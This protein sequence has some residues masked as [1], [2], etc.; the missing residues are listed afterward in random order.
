MARRLKIVSDE[1]LP[2]LLDKYDSIDDDNLDV[3][4]LGEEVTLEPIIELQEG[5]TTDGDGEASQDDPDPIESRGNSPTPTSSNMVTPATTSQGAPTDTPSFDPLYEIPGRRTIAARDGTKW[6]KDPTSREGTRKRKRDTNTYQAGP[7]PVTDAPSTL[8]EILALFL[9]DQMLSN[10]VTH[11]NTFIK[12]MRDRMK[13]PTNTYSDMTLMELDALLGVLITAGA[14]K[15]NHVSAEEM[16]SQ[17]F[18]CSVYRCAMSESRFSFLMRCLRFD[19]RAT[20]AER[21]KQDR[22]AP[23]RE[24]WDAFIQ[25]FRVNYIPNEHVMVDEQLLAFRGRCVFK[26]YMPKKPAK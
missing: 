19:D 18:G 20:R 6:S 9:D 22:F 10:I 11:T 16:F 15:D 23:I 14:K 8:P 5:D 3:V 1:E 7:T 25:H 26:M 13:K 17:E 12:D 24:V 4:D 2:G 21:R